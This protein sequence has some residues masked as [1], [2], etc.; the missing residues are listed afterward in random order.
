MS[1]R[2]TRWGIMLL[3][4]VMLSGCVWYG[5]HSVPFHDRGF[6]HHRFKHFDHHDNYRGH[7]YRHW[8]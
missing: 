1:K 5:G 7:D 4:T 8:R 6:R 2:T 3:L